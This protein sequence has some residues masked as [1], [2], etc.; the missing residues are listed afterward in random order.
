ML[1]HIAAQILAHGL[2][3]PLHARE[4]I[5]HASRRRVA[6]RLRQRL[7]ILVL[8]GQRSPH[9]YASARCRGSTRQNRGPIRAITSAK[10]FPQSRASFGTDP[11]PPTFCRDGGRRNPGSRRMHPM[12]GTSFDTR[13]TPKLGCSTNHPPL[14]AAARCPLLPSTWR[15]FHIACQKIVHDLPDIQKQP[16]TRQPSRHQTP[17]RTS[18]K[19]KAPT[20]HRYPNRLR[21]APMGIGTSLCL[22]RRERQF[23]GGKT[24]PRSV[25]RLT[26]S[27]ISWIRQL[28]GSFLQRRKDHEPG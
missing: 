11:T 17:Q 20:R 6:R 27:R 13:Q 19:K 23:Q 9:K 10:A 2:G 28:M 14:A 26:L 1:D 24:G 15:I 4:K 16:P 8:R 22:K 25:K 18:T 21:L 3:I 12:P 5:V 7:A